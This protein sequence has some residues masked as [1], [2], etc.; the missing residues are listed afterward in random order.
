MKAFKSLKPK[1]AKARNS[2]ARRI[3]RKKL[4]LFRLMAVIAV[5]VVLLGILECG[6]RLVG[7]GYSTGAMIK[8]ESDWPDIYHSNSRFGWRFFPKDISRELIPFAFDVHKTPQTYRIFVLGASAAAGV[9]EPFYNFGRFLEILLTDKY[10]LTKFEVV[11]VAMPAINSH[12]VLEAARDCAECEPDLFIVYMGNN[13]VVGPFGPGSIFAPLAPNLSVIRANIA[14][15]S[16]RTGQLLEQAL[17]SAAPRGRTPQRWD[18]M[19]MFL[20]KQVPYNDP[21]LRHVYSHFEQNLKDIIN[22]G[23]KAR[24]N[25]IVSN[26]GS[27]LKD[28]PPFAS[29]HRDGLTKLEKIAWETD[30]R[31]GVNYETNGQYTRAIEKYLAAAKIDETFADLQFRLGRCYW[32]GGHYEAAK[33]RYLKALEYDTL[34]FRADPRINQIIQS[35]ADGRTSKG[36]YFV[37]TIKALETNS[38]HHTPGN[39]LFHEHVHYQFGGNYL[40]ATTLLDTIEKILP[41][42]VKQ[43]KRD[44][45]TLTLQEC[46]DRLV[47]T[48]YEEYLTARRVL[49]DYI[50]SPPFTNQ[51]YHAGR[52]N[53]LEQELDALKIYTEKSYLETVVLAYYQQI[54]DHPDDWKLRYK[55]GLVLKNEL[56]EPDPALNEFKQVLTFLPEGDTYSFIVEILETQEKFDEASG[57]YRHLQQLRPG[58]RTIYY[59]Q[60]RRA[61]DYYKDVLEE[62]PNDLQAL[63]NLAWVESASS[64]QHVRHPEQ[65]LKHAQKLCELTAYRSAGCLDTLAAAYA[66]N[67]DFE[68]AAI[69]AEKAATIATQDGNVAMARSIQARLELYR[70]GKMYFD[71]GLK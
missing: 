55:L 66:A 38:P 33:D 19:E 51:L 61:V 4:W 14:A 52:V 2:P 21:G 26:V 9:P 20:N 18:G 30:Y 13:E 65:G 42:P 27:N 1:N 11:T 16:M 71:A 70:S 68:K 10:P 22:A 41:D 6:L 24:A 29:Q 35:V 37:D 7:F 69:T 62:K 3:S 54:K 34:R 23:L 8:T 47:L 50:K 64:I 58:Y 46:K 44:V 56:R 40:V 17:Q 57:Y 25:V 49:T 48:G 32:N 43:Q 12:A 60:T 36:V 67:G 45:V 63:N 31:G 53:K 59:G 5:P 28:S 15:K 39:E